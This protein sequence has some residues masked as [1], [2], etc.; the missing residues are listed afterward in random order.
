MRKT[1]LQTR[2]K[3]PPAETIRLILYPR[4]LYVIL[5]HSCMI[6]YITGLL[7]YVFVLQHRNNCVN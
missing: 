7:I 6:N 4:D 1:S 3:V 2:N 5:D